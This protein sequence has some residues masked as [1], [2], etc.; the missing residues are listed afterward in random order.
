[1]IPR[2]TMT[3]L[4]PLFAVLLATRVSAQEVTG[5][6]QGRIWSDAGSPIEMVEIAVTST[7][8]TVRRTGMTDRF[9]RFEIVALPIGQYQVRARRLGYRPVLVAGVTVRLGETSRLTQVKMDRAPQPL[10]ELVISA[11]QAGLEQVT[12]GSSTILDAAKLGELPI[13]R[14]FRDIAMLM[15]QATPSFYGDA[16]S[17]GGAT[18]LENQ[19]YVDGIKI[20][21]PVD[22]ARSLDLPYNFID[23]IQLL[24]GGTAVED[25]QAL[26]GVINVVTPSGSNNFEQ[27]VFGYFSSDGLET[28]TREAAGA[29]QTGFREFDAGIALSGPVIRDRLWFFAAYNPTVVRR[30]HEFDFGGL[31]L[32]TRSH[33]FATKL[34]TVIGAHTS[35][36][37]TLIGSPTRRED[38]QYAPLSSSAA[39]PLNP[40]VLHMSGRR[41]GIAWALRASHALSDRLMLEESVSRMSYDDEVEPM[42]AA[43]REPWFYDV[44]AGTVSGGHGHWEKWHGSR[45]SARSA[46][47]WRHGFQQLKVG[48]EYELVSLSR[49]GLLHTITRASSD[50]YTEF[51]AWFFGGKAELRIPSAFV[52]WSARP[53]PRM[54]TLLGLRWSQQKIGNARANGMVL[55]TLRDGY[56]PRIGLTYE[57]GER[58]RHRL[59]AAFA[60]IVDEASLWGIPNGFGEGLTTSTEY[61]GDPRVDKTGADTLW[62]VASEDYLNGIPRLVRGIRS[63]EYSVGLSSR[64]AQTTALSLRVL[65]RS[66]RS[67]WEAGRN[68]GAGDLAEFPDAIRNHEAIETTITGTLGPDVWYR[69]SYTLS[70]TRGNQTGDY[71]TDYRLIT[72]HSGPAWG[73]P[74]QFVNANG[75]LPQD[76]THVV[77]LYGARRWSRLT[78]GTNLIVAS[79]T[80]LSE[81]G[82]I[83]DAPF[84]YFG[85]LS[86][87]GTAGRTPSV[88]DLGLRFGYELPV[89]RTTGARSRALLDLQHVGSPRRAVDFDQMRFTCLDD[90]GMPACP[91]ATY[92]RALQFQPPMTARIGV[93]TSFGGLR[94]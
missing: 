47:S 85:F 75:L 74:A 80:P 19:Y 91:N 1:M 31:G 33:Q 21:S 78:I 38:L 62:Q 25:E 63:D 71:K 93:E 56:Q 69:G 18:G 23:Q 36:T 15:P 87:R 6:I 32:V 27:R 34:N 92:G 10:T 84:P 29:T 66:L 90:A 89:L 64:I 40:E 45:E 43:G 13:G 67:A 77:K 8:Q 9:G 46:I 3:R 57:I 72:P 17:I 86:K 37:A 81:M 12:S 7:N 49:D 59:E 30:D 22:A 26:G 68:P 48:G 41:G 52:H 51:D 83:P 14:N 20:T 58:G 79:G 50:T 73:Y 54:T 70:R 60:R 11:D 5:R 76:R 39:V 88:W 94:D 65:R 35:L 4:L 42:T 44:E 2:S 55:T 61:P 82:A 16:I 28:D 24:T 53:I